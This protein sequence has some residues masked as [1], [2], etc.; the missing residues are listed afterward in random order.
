MSISNKYYIKEIKGASLI[1]KYLFSMHKSNRGRGGDSASRGRN[2]S[3]GG[4][5]SSG[6]YERGNGSANR[7]K[8]PRGPMS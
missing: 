6:N 4:K 7:G 3:R 8:S 2:S 5:P 1:I